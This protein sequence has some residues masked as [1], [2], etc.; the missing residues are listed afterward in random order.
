MLQ[1]LDRDRRPP[2]RV[3]MLILWEAC[4]DVHRGHDDRIED[5]TVVCQPKGI[6][7]EG[8]LEKSVTTSWFYIL[9]MH[10]RGRKPQIGSSYPYDE[11]LVQIFTGH[12]GRTEDQSIVCQPRGIPREECL[13]KSASRRVPREE[14][15]EK[16]APGSVTSSW[17][18]V[19]HLRDRDRRP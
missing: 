3:T 15:L 13:E 1:V 8:C 10:D 12:D 19:L 7:R 14:C 9:Q 16:S 11:K 6:L 17:L 4:T 5:H 2:D 18:H